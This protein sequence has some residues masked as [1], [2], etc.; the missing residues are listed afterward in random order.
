MS[1]LKTIIIVIYSFS[2]ASCSVIMAAQ[3]DGVSPKQLSNCRTRSCI[4]SA[5]GEPLD[6]V[7]NSKQI[8]VSEHFRALMPKGSAARAAMH[9]VLD[10][11]TFG[12]WEVAGTPI[13]AVKK[14]DTRYVVAVTYENDGQTIK[15]I[16][17]EF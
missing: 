13:E 15:K 5:G 1:F 17:F 4:I 6:S 3:K 11:A 14:K 8:L 16:N 2:L 7:K 10:V 12:I 9:G